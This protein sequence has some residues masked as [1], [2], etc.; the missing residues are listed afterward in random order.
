MSVISNLVRKA[1]NKEEKLNILSFFYDGKF[2][3][4]LLKTGHHFYGILESSAYQWPGFMKAEYKNLHIFR[5][6]NEVHHVDIDLV[7]FNSRHAH[8]Q[9][10]Q[11]CRQLHAP[12]LIIDHDQNNQNAFFR[13][14][15]KQLTPFPH[16]STSKYVSSQY[17]CGLYISNGV[18][19]K[20]WEM[21]KDIDILCTASLQHDHNLI[22][23]IRQ[24][25]PTA[26]FIG[27]NPN[28][29]F[30]GQVETYDNYK[31]LFKRCRVFVNIS[32]QMNINHEVLFALNNKVPIITPKMAIYNG[33]LQDKVNCLEVTSPDDIISKIK[34][35]SFD[36]ALY[37]KIS[38]F[39]TDLS[40]FS[41]TVFIDRW[42]EELSKHASRVYIE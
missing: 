12:G 31:E 18:E 34:E 28:L 42:K 11:I 25:F 39:T 2:D 37:N 8:N 23:N 26:V 4:E 10:F 20:N 36:K 5:D 9:F 7:I 32:P 22:N 17:D 27:H 35:L 6:L 30:V 13:E 15:N 38:N 16:I 19:P 21:D 3:I 14:K 24:N 1:T 29:P 41:E 40:D 33:L